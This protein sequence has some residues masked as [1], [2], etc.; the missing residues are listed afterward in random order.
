[1][2]DQVSAVILAGGKSSRF[3]RNK[4]LADYQGTPLI[5]RIADR[6]TP[7]FADQLLITNTPAEYEFLNWPM[8]GDL[9]RD[10]GPLA[11][12]QAAL[13]SINQPRAFV[14][15]CDMPLLNPALIRHL[16][17]IEGEWDII[18]P[19]LPDG[20]EPLYAVYAQTALPVITELLQQGKRKIGLLFELL[21]VRRVTEQEIL[22]IVPDLSCF[23]NINRQHDLHAISGG[24]D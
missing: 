22:A 15:G 7:L 5:Q 13:L 2:I 18:L 11:G 17:A 9:H 21:K 16:C 14:C 24:N 23:H 4:A 8:T 6:L 1:M 3:G 20:P 10:C 12:I 19:W